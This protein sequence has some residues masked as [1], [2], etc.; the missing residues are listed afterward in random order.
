MDED[1]YG[2][3]DV[4]TWKALVAEGE[5]L[6]IH[7]PAMAFWVD[8]VGN[9]KAGGGDVAVIWMIRPLLEIQASERRVGWDDSDERVKYGLKERDRRPISV[10]KTWHWYHQQRPFVCNA[11][12]LAY[13][14]LRKHRLWIPSYRRVTFGRRQWQ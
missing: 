11:F 13:H 1:E 10:V 9:E 2:T 12:E 4:A 8:E 7:S 3:K 14:D 6:V 5:E